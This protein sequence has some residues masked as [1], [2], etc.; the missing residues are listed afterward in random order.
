MSVAPV[1]STITKAQFRELE[2][3][4][5]LHDGPFGNNF[6]LVS[7]H[8][9]FARE[10]LARFW[11]PSFYDGRHPPGKNPLREP[12]Q[13]SVLRSIFRRV[14]PHGHIITF[15]RDREYDF[16]VRFRIVI[17]YPLQQIWEATVEVPADRVGEI[18]ALA[19]DMYAHIY[20]LDDEAWEVDGHY[21]APRASPKLANRAAGKHV[22]G[23]DM[24]DL[25]IERLL[26]VPDPNW[27]LR[28]RREMVI[29]EVND[30]SEPPPDPPP[31]KVLAPAQL[32]PEE[33][34]GARPFLGTILFWI[35]S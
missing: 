15:G 27:P 18:F 3:S 5:E 25:V 33:H 26:F 14:L 12:G 4:A 24:G 23:H 1:P 11:E 32:D 19:Y 16:P 29:V 31:K 10:A 30:F 28:E 20:R 6:Q 17:S 13:R 21:E 34:R 35:G 9:D 8:D 7:L 2:Q 22:W